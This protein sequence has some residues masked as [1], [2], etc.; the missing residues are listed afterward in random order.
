[1]GYENIG[2]RILIKNK[3]IIAR[4]VDVIEEDTNLI[5]F[6]CNDEENNPANG[7]KDNES[8]SKSEKITEDMTKKNNLDVVNDRIFNEQ[9]VQSQ[10]NRVKVT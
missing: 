7:A 6:K 8:P 4:H 3:V 1:M 10:G 9:A 2:Y 5:G